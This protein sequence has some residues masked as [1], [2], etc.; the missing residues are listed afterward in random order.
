MASK[1]NE[2]RAHANELYIGKLVQI[3]TFCQEIIWQ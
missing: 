3:V 2:D 1:N